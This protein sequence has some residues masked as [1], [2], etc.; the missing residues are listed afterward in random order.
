MHKM[1]VGDLDLHKRMKKQERWD[2][3]ALWTKRTLV[4]IGLCAVL[5]AYIVVFFCL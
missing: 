2:N 3:I 5:W 1:Y 4:A